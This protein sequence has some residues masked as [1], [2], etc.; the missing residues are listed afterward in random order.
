MS[1]S[2]ESTPNSRLSGVLVALLS[3]AA[4][5]LCTDLALFPLDTVKTRLQS[6]TGFMAAGGFRGIYS[7]LGSVAMGSMPGSALFFCTYEGIKQMLGGRT[8]SQLVGVH[9][10]AAACGEVMACIVRV[11]CEVVKQRAQ[12]SPHLSSLNVLRTTVTQE[13]IAGLYRGYITTV[14]REIPFSLIQFPLWEMFKSRWTMWQGHEVVAWQSALCGCLAGGI[15]ACV[16]TP[17]DVAKTR[18]MLAPSGT[19]LATDGLIHALRVVHSE[20][21][22]RGLFAGVVPRVMLISVGGAIFLGAY[23]KVRLTLGEFGF[24]K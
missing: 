23:D 8:T 20:N 22:S 24:N 18:I 13:G 21:G 1:E 2:V 3:G 6:A 4:A 9:M 12:M 11:P 14:L 19:A 16:T 10:S 5:G 15:S 7:G 17:L